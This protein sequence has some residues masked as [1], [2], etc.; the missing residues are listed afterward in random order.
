[1]S[2]ARLGRIA[3]I[4]TAVLLVAGVAF[5]GKQWWNSRLPDTYNVMAYGTH[6]YGGGPEP[7]NHAARATVRPTCAST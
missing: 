7:A 6:D 1:M 5:L 2:R 4:T 3:A